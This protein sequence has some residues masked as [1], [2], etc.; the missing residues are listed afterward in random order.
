MKKVVRSFAIVQ[1]AALVLLSGCTPRYAGQPLQRTGDE[2]VACGQLFHTGTPVVLWTDPGGYDAYRTERRYVPWDRAGYQKT[3]LEVKVFTDYGPARYG[4]RSA[5]I[6]DAA[7]ERVRGGGW[8]LPTLQRCIDQFV[9][10]YD[11]CGL[12]KICFQT[13][14]DQRD[15]SIHF[16]LD[17]DG[18][19]YQTLDVKERARHATKSNDRSIGI[20]LA[21]PGAYKNLLLVKQWYSKDARGKTCISIPARFGDGNLRIKGQLLRPAR[22]EPLQGTIQDQILRQYDYTPQQYAALIKLTATLCTVFPKITCD[23]PRDA[24][25]KVIDHVLSDSQWAGYQGLLGHYHVQKEKDD[26][27]PAFDWETVISGAKALMSPEALEANHQM[28]GCPARP[29]VR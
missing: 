18:T 6:D 29:V 23:V 8:D 28:L 2:I 20:E 11:A 14:Q 15:L 10:H 16:M 5:Q 9:I 26:P 1:L 12:S 25:G 22:S 24:S 27:G 13:L 17:I 21:N 3:E 19:I 4:I 7:L